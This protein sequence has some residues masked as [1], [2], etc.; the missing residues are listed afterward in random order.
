M[1]FLKI[2]SL[3]LS[4]IFLTACTNSFVNGNMLVK[5]TDKDKKSSVKGKK[6]SNSKSYTYKVRGKTYTTLGTHKNYNKQGTASWYGKP[7]HG[8]KTASGEIYNMYAM[9]AAHKSLPLGSKV[10]VTDIV[11]QRSVIVKVN[12][13]G[14]FHGNRLIDLSYA[15]ANKLGFIHSGVSRVEVTALK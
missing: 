1:K 10:K 5:N 7:F 8:R 4:L 2:F 3:A 13:R 14:P 11:N 12:D 15:A 6:S 9:T